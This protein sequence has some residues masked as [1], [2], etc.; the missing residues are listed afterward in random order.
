MAAN[1]DLSTLEKI[2]EKTL[3]SIE[4]SRSEIYDVIEMARS[5][6]K[7]IEG[8]LE[9]I[10]GKVRNSIELVE[11]LEAQ[12]KASRLRLI[13]VSRNFSKYSE[14]DIK[15]AYERAQDFQVKLALAREWE[16]Q[17]RDKRDE[18][19]RNLKN[20]D[21]IIRKAENLLNQV[22][23]TMDYLR[24]SFRELNNKVE[25][26]QQRQQLGFQIIKVQEE[27]RR[28]LARE[29]H[30][31][32]AQ[33]LVNVILRLE[34]CQKIME[35]D[36]EKAREELNDMKAQVRTSLQEVRRIIFD[37]RPM[38]LDDLGLVPA[39]RKYLDEYQQKFKID[40]NFILL[41][42][43]KRIDSVLEVAIFR[44]IQEALINAYKHSGANR[45]DVRL[46]I[47]QSQVTVVVEDNGRGFEVE[48]VLSSASTGE[49]Y[50]LINMRERAELFGGRVIFQS[51][52]GKGTKV[53]TRFVLDN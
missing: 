49:H 52:P 17:L 14:E 36:L 33:S 53:I 24:G 18:L 29:I 19:E 50:G 51:E 3:E 27:E 23:V 41:G 45:I 32:P 38:I 35:T 21:F 5:E 30:D 46:E 44:I 34:V 26:I 12:S 48:K 20:L 1:F 40:T 42:K 25:S 7:R 28:R 43:E 10:K 15:E 4:T 22:S 16:K 37:L 6:Q 47:S 8:E 39:I 11:S 13:E 9:V 31:G 2:I